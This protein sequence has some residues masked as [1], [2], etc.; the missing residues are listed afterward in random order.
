VARIEEDRLVFDMKA[1]DAG[2]IPVLAGKIRE[3]LGDGA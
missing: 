3:A 1:V 2:L